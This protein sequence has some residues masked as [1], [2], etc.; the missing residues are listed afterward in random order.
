M[1]ASMSAP[2]IARTEDPFR[3]KV[4]FCGPEENR[5][6][7][8]WSAAPRELVEDLFP[9]VISRLAGAVKKT[10]AYTVSATLPMNQVTGRSLVLEATA[11]LE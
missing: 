8:W 11:V 1:L 4:N 7:T 9:E 3:R 5:V 6:R 2:C 10:V